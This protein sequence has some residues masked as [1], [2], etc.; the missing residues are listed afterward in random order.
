MNKK[1]ILVLADHPL[2]PSGVGTQTKYFIEAL[3]KTGRYQFVCLGGAI[4]HNSYEQQSID[5]WGDDFR[6]FPV[7]GYGSHEMIRSILRKERPDALWFMTDPRFF[8]WLWE[9][10]NEVRAVV[11]MIYYHV[12]DNFPLPTFNSRYYRST[13]E[14]VTIS[15]VTDEIVSKVA[16]DAYCRRIPHAVNQAI[17]HK[18]KKD[19]AEPAIAMRQKIAN[20]SEN[21]ANPN[22]KIFFWNN[23]NARRKQPGTLI[24]WFK[25]FLDEV[26]HDKATLLMHTDARDNHGQDL[27]QIIEK[28]GVDDGQVLLSTQK[29]APGDLANMYN[30]VDYT[31]NIADAEG[32][33]LS[34]LESMMC[35]TPIIVNMTGGLKEQVTNGKEWFG[36]GIEPASKA[37]I[38]SLTV[39]FIYE[40]R[41][42]K[43]DFLKVMRKAL[44]CTKKAYQNMSA[45]GI[46]HAT[47]NYGFEDFETQW[48]ETMDDII[49]RHG[50]WET[51][52][53]Y[54]KWHLWEIAA[55]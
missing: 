22:K 3:L 43:E 44:K 51:R 47:E 27:P 30:A 41:I 9:I 28:L 40:D 42:S 25:E 1:K 21:F 17:F 52:K 33:G 31:I 8:D 54:D 15:K 18:F 32:F 26:G 10:E 12:W 50:S 45:G 49:E 53:N 24:W 46:K 14:I 23:R 39:P 20:S 29:V 34:T 11:P 35:G 19:E 48:V 7:D 37:V 6:V 2:S 4:K 38:G 13:D 16:P 5:P 55:K 36:W